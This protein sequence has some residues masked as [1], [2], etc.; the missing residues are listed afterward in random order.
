VNTLTVRV[1]NQREVAKRNSGSLRLADRAGLAQN[2]G[3]AGDALK[4]LLGS[5]YAAFGDEGMRL[6]YELLLTVGRAQDVLDWLRPEHEQPLTPEGYHWLRCRACAAVGDYAG[7]DRELAELLR[8]SGPPLPAGARRADPPAAG[9]ARAVAV[10]GGVDG[11]PLRAW[12]AAMAVF[13]GLRLLQSEGLERQRAELLTLRG[14]LSLEAGKPA[15]AEEHFVAALAL[16][17]DGAGIDFAGR[18][19]ALANLEHIRAAR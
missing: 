14:V 5:D 1:E 8:G 6:E 16:W 4:L 2:A 15:E 3:L 12:E 18:H 10:S 19:V 11:S 13:D 7:A 9:P 17:R